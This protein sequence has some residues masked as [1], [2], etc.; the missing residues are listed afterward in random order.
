MR[1]RMNWDR[2]R[3]ENQMRRFGTERVLTEVELGGIKSK[4]G[5]TE[6]DVIRVLRMRDRESTGRLR[7]N[8]E[9]E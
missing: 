7:S 8:Q 1:R 3:K 2:V 4:A 9:G 5:G 6:V